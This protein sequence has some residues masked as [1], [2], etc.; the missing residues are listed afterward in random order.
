MKHPVLVVSKKNNTSGQ[1]IGCP[2]IK[3]SI[4]GPLHIWMKTDEYEGYVH[5]E[6]T[7]FVG[8]ICS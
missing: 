5:C 4:A 1:I 6:K 8:F 2:I 7:C 3:D